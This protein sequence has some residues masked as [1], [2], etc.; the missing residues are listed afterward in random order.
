MARWHSVDPLAEKY[1]SA[2]P[3]CYVLNTPINAIDPDGRLVIFVTGYPKKVLSNYSI[4]PYP[5]RIRFDAN[6]TYIHDRPLST[7]GSNY[8]QGLDRAFQSYFQDDNSLYTFG[9]HRDNS[10]AAERIQRGRDAALVFHRKF[11]DGDI[12]LADDETIKIV[13]HS[14]GA[15]YSAGLT[16]ELIRLGYQVEWVWYVAAHQPTDFSHPEGATGVQLI[17]RSDWVSSSQG[18]NWRGRQVR[19]ISPS[20]YGR[21]DGVSEF[22]ELDNTSKGRG[23]HSTWTYVNWL[24]QQALN[25]GG[26]VTINGVQQ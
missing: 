19:G 26:T 12:S 22:I 16:S 10:T 18:S 4:N 1:Y 15:A 20:S 24:M 25:N 5:P 7:M 14:H 8:W 13:G 11:I 23:G 9:G 17:R 21:I 2:S 6:D 3:Y